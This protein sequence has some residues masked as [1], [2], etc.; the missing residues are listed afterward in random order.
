MRD[1]NYTVCAPKGIWK[2]RVWK[3]RVKF[4]LNGAITDRVFHCEIGPAIIHNNRYKSWYI[5]GMFI[6]TE[7]E[8]KQLLKLKAFW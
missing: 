4:R 2:Y 5:N 1:F 8:F 3:Y 7:K 6:A